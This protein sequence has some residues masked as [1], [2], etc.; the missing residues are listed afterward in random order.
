MYPNYGVF[1]VQNTIEIENFD[2]NFLCSE[3]SKYLFRASA[4]FLLILLFPP[5]LLYLYCNIKV[6]FSS[7]FSNLTSNSQCVPLCC[8]LSQEKDVCLLI[9][10]FDFFGFFKIIYL[11]DCKC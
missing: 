1:L 7:A 4:G 10:W 11:C 3:R 6:S 8:F 2:G 5:I 9:L